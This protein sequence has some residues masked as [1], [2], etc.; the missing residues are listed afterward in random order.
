MARSPFELDWLTRVLG[1]VPLRRKIERPRFQ[2]S[3]NLS[4]WAPQMRIQK[5]AVTTLALLSSTQAC[6]GGNVCV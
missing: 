3:Q 6:C 5:V 2:A 4:Q 1:T